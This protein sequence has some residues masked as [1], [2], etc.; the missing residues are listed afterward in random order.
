M[1]V[2]GG[3]KVGEATVDEEELVEELADE[4]FSDAE[5]EVGTG[6]VLLLFTISVGPV[7]LP[8]NKPPPLTLVAV[9]TVPLG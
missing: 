3:R 1:T 5:V 2:M 4:E 8:L 7:E 6:V 9:I